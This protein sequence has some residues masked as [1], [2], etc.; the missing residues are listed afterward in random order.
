MKKFLY[1]LIFI[2]IIGFGI[3]YVYINYFGNLIPKI[4]VEEEL[5]NVDEYYIYG[6]HLNIKGN[7]KITDINYKDISF[8]LYNG[9][10]KSFEVNDE[11]EEKKWLAGVTARI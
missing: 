7:L 9:E 10:E 11:K 8:V 3:Y 1:T 4:D 6:N 2:I 5:A